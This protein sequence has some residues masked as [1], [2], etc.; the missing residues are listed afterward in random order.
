MSVGNTFR[1]VESI[2]LGFFYTK[3]KDRSSNTYVI[4]LV[5]KNEK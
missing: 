2:E 1:G 5:A 4:A 3:K